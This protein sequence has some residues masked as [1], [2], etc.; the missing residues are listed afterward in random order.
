MK[1]VC[2]S[3]Y[4]DFQCAAS[5]CP[6]SCCHQWTVVVDE[7]TAQRYHQLEGPLGDR[8]RQVMCREEG[9]MILRL[10]PDGRCPMW[11]DDGL[12]RI[13]AELGEA[14]LC[15][16]CRD[17]PRLRHDYGDFVEL[18]LELSCPVA[19]R[20]ILEDRV[21]RDVC[22]TV[23]GGESPD[24]DAHTM[25]ILLHSRRQ[26]LDF[27]KDTAMSVPD[28]L[29]VL[30]LYGYHVQEELDGGEV[31]VL[32]PERLLQTARSLAQPGSMDDLRAF[33]GTLEVLTQAWTQRLN[34][35]APAPWEEAHR[36]MARYFINRYWLQAVSDYDLVS[37]V[38]LAVISCLMV[39]HLGGDV[40]ETA[41]QYSKEI[42]NDADNI[43][44]LLDAAYTHPA[45]ADIRLLGL[46]ADR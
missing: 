32:D 24:Y 43:D 35:P 21:C 13:H 39:R 46:L 1:L 44:A 5:A 30:L 2:P 41:Q 15:D 6:D 33:F 9:D 8:L 17:F 19:A 37:R 29:S 18:G 7:E 10:R 28:A 27:L 42:E 16:T 36:A 12:C 38:K 22:R 40:Y 4:A 3:Y 34:A 23:P 20:L 25:Q 26:I 14:A 31:A 11:R 45:L